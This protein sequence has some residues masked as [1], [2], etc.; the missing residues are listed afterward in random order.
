M[1]TADKYDWIK[2]HI[3]FINEDLKDVEILI[4]PH[5][6]C[7]ETCRIEDYKPLNTKLQY[8]VELIIPSFYDDSQEWVMCHDVD[9]D[10]SGWT[11]E[12]AIDNLY[13]LVLD[14]YGDY[15]DEDYKKKHDEVFDELSIPGVTMWSNTTEFKLKDHILRNSDLL[16]LDYDLESKKKYQD[17]LLNFHK[18]ATVQQKSEIDLILKSVECEI[19]E[20]EQELKWGIRL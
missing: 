18:H 10:C 11:Y 9:C 20:I 1:N 17:A 8:W 6:V 5:N 7:P 15:T 19:W 4:D 13:N 16:S 3:A 12:E 2:N 14:K